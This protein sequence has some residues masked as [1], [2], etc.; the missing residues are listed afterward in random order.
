[1]YNGQK[2]IPADYQG[3]LQNITKVGQLVGLVITG[4]CQERYG[5]KRTY[6]GGMIIMTLS[7]FMAVFAVSLDMLLGAE[8]I[9]GI[10]W[11]MFREY[12]TLR[13]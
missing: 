2:V 10:P 7:I 8:L 9:M 5:S 12:Y 13:T 6:I 4:Y 1:M 3:G 11:G